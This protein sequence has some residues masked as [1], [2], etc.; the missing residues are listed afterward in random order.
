MSISMPSRIFIYY[1]VLITATYLFFFS[2]SSLRAD[3][4][5]LQAPSRLEAGDPALVKFLLPVKPGSVPPVMLFM[6]REFPIYPLADNQ[7]WAGIIGADLRAEPGEY[8]LSLRQTD[9]ILAR[10]NIVVAA[11]SGGARDIRVDDKYVSPPDQVIE[12]IKAESQR[13]NDVYLLN[14]SPVFWT[15][16]LLTPLNSAV[17]GKF[18]RSSIINGQPRSPHGGVDLRGAPGTAVKCPAEGRVVLA[19]DTYFSGLLVLLD[20]G[21]GLISGYRH[22]SK[23]LVN[24][25]DML[26]QGQIIGLVGATGRVTGPHLHF[27]IHLKNATID[28]LKFVRLSL[29]LAALIQD[30][31]R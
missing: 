10:R 7:G 13:Q 12:R 22:L 5:I 14:T 2:S 25:G 24:E 17:V 19:M 29:E 3:E 6:E 31:N 21:Q 28:P 8:I 26:T 15:D 1:F 16:G 9:Q 11:R 30:K 20:H 4:A 23:I 18:G 27:D